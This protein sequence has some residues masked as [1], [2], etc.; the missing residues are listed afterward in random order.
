MSMSLQDEAVLLAGAVGAPA[1]ATASPSGP[2]GVSS[3]SDCAC[4]EA[5]PA[6]APGSGAGTEMHHLAVQWRASYK[7]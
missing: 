4:S 5:L 7:R 3:S 2:Y 6:A 1:M